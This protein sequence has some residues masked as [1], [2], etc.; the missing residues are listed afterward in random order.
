MKASILYFTIFISDTLFSP[1]ESNR[2]DDL[3]GCIIHLNRSHIEIKLVDYFVSDNKCFVPPLQENWKYFNSLYA[4]YNV[5]PGIVTAIFLC[6]PHGLISP[7]HQNIF[8]M[9]TSIIRSLAILDC[10]YIGDD[11]ISNKIKSSGNYSTSRRLTKGVLQN[12]YAVK[13]HSPTIPQTIFKSLAIPTSPKPS[14]TPTSPVPSKTPSSKPSNKPS[15]VP[16]T[17]SPTGLPTGSTR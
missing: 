15:L 17:S 12:S 16:T 3:I 9:R 7:N 5:R 11:E 2:G 6:I 4:L 1:S 14:K 10:S 8:I 13:H